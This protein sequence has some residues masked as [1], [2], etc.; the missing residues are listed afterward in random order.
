MY[1]TLCKAQDKNN[2]IIRTCTIKLQ[3][4]WNYCIYKIQTNAIFGA[5]ETQARAG[6]ELRKVPFVIIL[7]FLSCCRR[8]IGPSAFGSFGLGDLLLLKHSQ[9]VFPNLPEHFRRFL[10]AG[11]VAFGGSGACKRKL[12]HSVDDAQC[13]RRPLQLRVH[14]LLHFAL[15]ELPKRPPHCHPLLA[16]PRQLYWPPPCQ[17][18]HQ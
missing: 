3:E 9:I 17:Y 5:L 11:S 13:G 2:R 6:T 14:H 15:H 16:P 8:S 18:L 12:R 1:S 10:H 7:S 4:P